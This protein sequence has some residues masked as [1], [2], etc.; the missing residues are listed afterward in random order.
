MKKLTIVLAAAFLLLSGG[1]AFS[2]DNGWY[3]GLGIGQSTIDT[4]VSA[5]TGTAS[6]DEEGT[7]LKVFAGYEINKYIAVE[8]HYLDAG[9]ASLTG[10]TG[11]TFVADGTAYVFTSNNVS[12]NAEAI[13]Y[14]LSGVFTYPLHQYFAP[15]AK[16]GFQKW[17]IDATVSNGSSSASITDDGTGA[18]F[19]VG[20][21]ADI[22]ENIS[23]RAE[24]ERYDIDDDL[25]I[26]SASFVYRF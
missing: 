6:L 12:I 1:Y 13:S 17:D 11:D 14:G 26:V 7:A 15:F 18:L 24:F 25:D 23:V 2:A 5:T 16:L 22:T 4:G 19:G 9:E 21:R 8:A 20:V 3:V 10:N